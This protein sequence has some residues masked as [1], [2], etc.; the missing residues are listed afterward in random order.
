ML[1]A[2][3]ETGFVNEVV[4]VE[5]GVEEAQILATKETSNV[6]VGNKSHQFACFCDY[7]QTA[8]VACEEDRGQES[9]CY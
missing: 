4:E 6:A 3:M 5:S 2:V 9:G 8:L 7:R 1:Q